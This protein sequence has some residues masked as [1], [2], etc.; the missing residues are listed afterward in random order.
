MSHII[1]SPGKYELN[2]LGNVNSTTGFD[3]NVQSLLLNMFPTY[4]VSTKF[5]VG[6]I[7]LEPSN[8][9]KF[10]SSVAYG[11]IFLIPILTT[12]SRWAKGARSVAIGTTLSTA[13]G[14]V[15]P[16]CISIK[17][18]LTNVFC[19]FSFQSALTDCT[20]SPPLCFN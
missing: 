16:N 8:T 6:K 2:T 1:I 15:K 14:S 17:L 9:H 4:E 20:P 10:R 5:V 3:G 18:S 19:W 7:L 13:S 11:V 12:W